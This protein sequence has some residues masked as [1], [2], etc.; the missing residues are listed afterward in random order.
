[1]FHQSIVLCVSVLFSEPKIP[2]SCSAFASRKTSSKFQCSSAS[3]KFLNSRALS[4]LSGR[5]AVSVLFSEP[6]IPQLS[7][8]IGR[9]NRVLEFQCSSASRKFLNAFA[10]DTATAA[11]A[12]QCS[13][14]SRKFLN[15]MTSP[16]LSPATAVSV[17]FSEPKIPQFTIHEVRNHQRVRFSALQRAEN[18]SIKPYSGASAS[19]G[20]F[21]AL[22]RAENSSMAQV[23]A[24]AVLVLRFSALQRAENSSIYDAL[25]ALRRGDE[26]QCSSASRK[27]LNSLDETSGA[28]GGFRFSALQRAE[29]SSIVSYSPTL[30]KRLAVSVLFSEPK[31]P[32]SSHS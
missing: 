31:I 9:A 17:L 4:R 30:A 11:R 15:V 14:A 16:W 19:T 13:S 21:S 2:Q 10:L 12:F 7:S 20:S 5:A 3:R 23:A 18:S 1:M 27:F 8:S 22:Q 29:N 28:S 24:T 25:E 32:Q 6:K 26:F